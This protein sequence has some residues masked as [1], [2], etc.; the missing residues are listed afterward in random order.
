MGPPTHHHPLEC[1]LGRV[2][3]EMDG[4]PAVQLVNLLG[5]LGCDSPQ[6]SRARGGLL[7]S[8]GACSGAPESRGLGLKVLSKRSL[9]ERVGHLVP[10][11][12]GSGGRQVWV[13]LL[14]SEGLLGVEPGHPDLLGLLKPSPLLRLTSISLSCS[15]SY[16]LRSLDRSAPAVS[17]P[18][19]L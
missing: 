2:A 5:I 16:G 3:G 12:P 11:G 1:V 9:T 18:T 17:L 7:G 19:V 10:G 13:A 14:P 4:T 15:L 6:V 8:S